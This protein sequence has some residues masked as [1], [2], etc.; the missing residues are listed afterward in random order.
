MS[1]LSEQKNDHT[2]AKWQLLASVS[3]LALIANATSQAKAED[4]EHP[5]VW[6]EAGA[7]L[8]RLTDG[9]ERFS[10]PF[11]SSM[12]E[13]PF[14]A[15]SELEAPPRYSF[16]QEGS[17]TFAPDGSD[18]A[19]SISVRYGRA[20][21]SGNRHEETSPPSPRIVESIPYFNINQ[22]GHLPAAAKRFAT[23]TAKTHT[24]DLIVD[25]QAG[26]DVGL[27]ITGK[28]GSST[29]N[30]GIRFAQFTSRSTSRIDSD[31]NFAVTYK[32]ITHIGAYSGY[33]KFPRQNWDLYSAKLDVSRG[34]TGV[35]PS[36]KWD[37]DAVLLGH[38]DASTVTF[39]WGLSGALLFGRQKVTAHHSTMA[40][41]GSAQVSHGPLPTVYPTKIHDTAR[42]RSVV[43]PNVGG[44]AGF[45]LRF[46]N[47]KVSLGY[48][49]DAFFGAMDGGIDARKTY[50]RDFYGPFATISI[51]LGG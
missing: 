5:T 9:E 15:P 33:I 48:R 1:E 14:T 47:A 38:P 46:P 13:N 3:A 19:F 45:S 7:Q 28:Y 24:S 26:K 39:D 31:P 12:L 50:D 22:T 18:W 49:V 17:I 27:G 4:T 25:F 36:L 32:Y 44:F 20:N 40:H 34:F 41:H 2:T 23:T 29:F 10:P 35:G 6:I 37:A 43:V 21:S 11:V 42:S 16:G 51:G 30:G 8:E